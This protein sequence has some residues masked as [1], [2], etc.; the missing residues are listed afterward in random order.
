M[1]GTDILIVGGGVIGAT[2]GWVLGKA[3]ASVVLVDPGGVAERASVG[4]LAW[5]NASSTADMDYARLRAASMR[6]WHEMAALHPDCPVTFPGAVMW[7][8]DAEACAAQV[9]RMATVGWPAEVLGRAAISARVP[10]LADVPEA[11]LFAPGEG[12]AHPDQITDW[13]RDQARG[14]GCQVEQAWVAEIV[15]Q[16]GARERPVAVVL[17]DGRRIEAAHIVV[18]AGNG[19]ADLLAGLGIDLPMRRSAGILMRTGPV[20]PVVPYVMATPRLDF[21]QDAAG[22]VLMSSSL[23]KTPE[24]ADDLMASDALAILTGMFPALAGA[25]VVETVRRDRPIPADGFPLVGAVGPKGLWVAAAH[26]GMTLAPAIAEALADEILGREAR[27]DLSH[28]PPL[29]GA[30]SRQERA[31]L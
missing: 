30:S 1:S 16:D 13:M 11:A 7:G 12:A 18:A 19:C 25:E 4:S 31:A 15:V 6:L 21:W 8:D 10:G 28:Y 3:G 26:S 22:C 5:L 24:R 23:A 14:A 20:A 17:D 27:F 2:L 29:R 9:Q